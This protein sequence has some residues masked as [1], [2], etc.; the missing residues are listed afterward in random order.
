MKYVGKT[1]NGI[2]YE[3]TDEEVETLVR[4]RSAALGMACPEYKEDTYGVHL[5]DTDLGPALQAAE[6][7]ATMRMGFNKLKIAL[8]ET[9][10]ALGGKIGG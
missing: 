1:K 4:L 10:K 8:E 6:K 9:E 5:M 7:W 3:L 2:L